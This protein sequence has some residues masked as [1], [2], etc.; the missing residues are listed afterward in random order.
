MTTTQYIQ[1]FANALRGPAKL[2]RLKLEC[3]AWD[4]GSITIEFYDLDDPLPFGQGPSLYK[5]FTISSDVADTEVHEATH[6]ML[7][8]IHRRATMARVRTAT[9]KGAEQ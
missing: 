2:L 8:I 6:W 9:Q 7:G 5:E 1:K 4:D 3:A